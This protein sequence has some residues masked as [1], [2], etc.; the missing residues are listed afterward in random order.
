MFE[1]SKFGKNMLTKKY[2]Y[3]RVCDKKIKNDQAVIA[4]HN[5]TDKHRKLFKKV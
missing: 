5:I 1:K 3:C 4:W 2:Y